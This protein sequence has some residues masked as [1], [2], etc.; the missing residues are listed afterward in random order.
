[1]QDTFATTSESS[2]RV[3]LSG[4]GSTDFQDGEY[5][6]ILAAGPPTTQTRR[7][8]PP[9]VSSPV[10]TGSAQYTYEC[11]GVD[12]GNGLYPGEKAVV[13]NAPNS[14]SATPIPNVSISRTGNVL[15]VG[16][17]NDFVAGPS[18]APT[19]VIIQGAVPE[20]L[21]GEYVISTSTP[22]L[23]TAT[24]GITV[25]GTETGNVAG[26]S[27]V[28]PYVSITCP[29][30]DLEGSSN[31]SL[32]SAPKITTI[33]YA[34][35]GNSSGAMKFIGMTSPVPITPLPKY[36]PSKQNGIKDWGPSLSIGTMPPT[37][38]PLEPPIDPVNQIYQ[39][40]VVS[41]GGTPELV[42]SPLTSSGVIGKAAYHDDG[43]ALL[44][45]ARAA[46]AFGRGTVFISPRRNSLVNAAYQINY[47]L[48]LPDS[49]NFT[50][51]SAM[52]V[53]ATITF[54]RADTI[55]AIF[56]SS[57][58]WFP[59]FSQRNY[60]GISGTASPQFYFPENA[61]S[62]DGIGFST[63]SNQQNSL[64]VTG[65]QQTIS[66]T[67]FFAGQTLSTSIIFQ[68]ALTA[69][70]LTNVAFV[71]SSSVVWPGPVVPGLWFRSD[72]VTGVPNMVVMDGVNSFSYRGI[73]IDTSGLNDNSEVNYIFEI[74]E[75]QAPSTPLLMLYGAGYLQNISLD[76]AV[77]DSTLAPAVA[78]WSGGVNGLSVN[79]VVTSGGYPQI[80]GL[81]VAGLTE[82]SSRPAAFPLGQNIGF[83]ASLTAPIS[84]GRADGLTLT[85]GETL[86]AQPTIVSNSDLYP[87]AFAY[88]PTVL[89]L[90]QR[91]GG[92]LHPGELYTVSVAVVGPNGGASAPTSKQI[93]LN[94]GNNA[95]TATWLPVQNAFGYDVFLNARK[96]DRIPLSP[97]THSFSIL[98]PANYGELGNLDGTGYPLLNR[99]GLFS[100]QISTAKLTQ[101]T[102]EQFA[103]TGVLVLGTFRFK[104]PVAY[105]AAPVCT[106]NDTTNTASVRPVATQTT[107]TVTG[108][109][110]DTIAFICV[111][112]PN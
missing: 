91:S 107:L 22:D 81:P 17:R 89:S 106:A 74:Q 108:P 10:I 55:N 68:G 30:V 97:G 88:A 96:L 86:I 90:G 53:N 75:D 25:V 84:Y 71:D 63:N 46:K 70:H 27:L 102:A 42:I 98:G 104:F 40:R 69:L 105:R 101:P 52:I 65:S 62:I 2:S 47:P 35:Y 110:G 103:G 79:Y 33:Q 80:T 18:A 29:D 109:Q 87:L 43:P 9:K 111:G 41:G 64:L 72:N 50:I 26:T 38:I 83:S 76:G 51:G 4:R 7:P 73:M 60:A 100:S 57:D 28:Y 95:I 93:T 85:T 54:G 12:R 48:Q 24:T 94:G 5:I 82:R 20:D 78:N 15:T 99:D 34:V 45:A 8:G 16:V 31:S 58:S 39:G 1:M 3:T 21:N 44:D 14:F 11:V 36:F 6:D 56:G 67:T 66:N 23:V 49:I 32:G 19:I 92:K 59:Q 37:G 112:N 13:T 61:N 77:M